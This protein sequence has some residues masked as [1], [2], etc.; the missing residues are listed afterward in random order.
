[1]TKL[2]RHAFYIFVIALLGGCAGLQTDFKEP[3]VSVTSFRALPSEGMAPRFEIGLHVTNPNRR[4]IA[5]EGLSYT[6]NIEG[7]QILT[8]VENELPVIEGYGEGDVT[9]T[10]TADLFN[11]ISLISD[12]L[13]QPR[14]SF[15]YEFVARLDLGGIYSDIPVEKKGQVS[16]APVAR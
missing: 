13:R 2:Y 11:S 10:A 14:D 3:T 16:L 5:L 15:T 8:G 6:V 9:L 12:L 7:H 1:M 4:A